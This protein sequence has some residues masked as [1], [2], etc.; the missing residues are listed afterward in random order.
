MGTSEKVRGA[1]MLRPRDWHTGSRCS[2]GTWPGPF[3]RLLKDAGWMKD[4]GCRMQK[5]GVFCIFHPAFVIQGA[6]FD[7]LLV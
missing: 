4:V 3:S 7:T 2:F 1:S 6:Y 5:T